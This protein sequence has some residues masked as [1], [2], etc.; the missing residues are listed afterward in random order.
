MPIGGQ[1][2]GRVFG[3]DERRIQEHAER[4]LLLCYPPEVRTAPSGHNSDAMRIT[5]RPTTCL[6]ILSL[7]DYAS[8][9]LFTWRVVWG[10]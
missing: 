1:L 2:V 9:F 8:L 5:V 3:G 10:L 7:Y 4:T 6:K